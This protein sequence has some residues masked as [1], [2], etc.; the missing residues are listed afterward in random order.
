VLYHQPAALAGASALRAAGLD[1]GAESG[2]IEL[3]VQRPRRVVDP[4]G[5]RTRQVA[6]YDGV[7]QAHLGPPRVRIEAAALQAASRARS[8]DAAVAVLGDVV[9]KRRT[10]PAR[11]LAALVGHPRLKHRRLLCT[12]L[13]DIAAGTNSA[14]ERRYL[15]DV[16]RAHGLPEGQRQARAASGASTSYRDVLYEREAALVELDGKL[17]HDETEDRWD[18]LDRD[19]DAAVAG[20]LTVRVGWRQVLDAC[21]L[22]EAVGAILRARG[23]DGMAQACPRC[24]G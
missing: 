22:A 24:D 15:R 9:Q 17:G 16:E 5:V 19:V 3:V 21:R 8:E 7:V 18:D 14:L 4:A 11:L 6:D 10:T 2:P 20:Q 1:I 23:W 13:A 12:V